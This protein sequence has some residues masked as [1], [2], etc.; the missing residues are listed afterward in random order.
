MLFAADPDYKHIT[1]Q[2]ANGPTIHVLY[3]GNPTKNQV[4]AWEGSAQISYSKDQKE[5]EARWDK[6]WEQMADAA[7]TVFP[8]IQKKFRSLSLPAVFI[9]S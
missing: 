5:L 6:Q 3:K 2:I 1:R 9:Y 4:A 8:F 7:V